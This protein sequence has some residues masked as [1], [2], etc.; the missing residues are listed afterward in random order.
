MAN[1][2]YILILLCVD[3]QPG[4]RNIILLNSALVA[5]QEIGSVLQKDKTCEVILALSE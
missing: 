2:Y 1:V 5:S 3:A 4:L